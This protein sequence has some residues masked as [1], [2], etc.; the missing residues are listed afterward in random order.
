MF[1][2]KVIL[3]RFL[4]LKSKIKMKWNRG[5]RMMLPSVLDVTFESCSITSPLTSKAPS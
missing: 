2:V 1:K 3:Q 4:A 5:Q